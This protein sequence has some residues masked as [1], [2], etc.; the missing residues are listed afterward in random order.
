MDASRPT[1]NHR[2]A[3]I[4]IVEDDP[5]ISAVVTETL[6]DEGFRV[7][8]AT[9]HADALTALT[10]LRFGLVLTD[11]AGGSDGSGDRWPDLDRLRAAAG[12]A[13]T[14]IFSAHHPSAFDGYVERGF[15]G[16]IAKPF[17][18]DGLLTVVRGALAR[19]PVAAER[20]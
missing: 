11:T 16:F 12:D 13:P 19:Q 10:A 14:V 18:L 17:D 9:K 8:A 3:T 20:D 6:R 5:S 2:P 1:T 7:V 15:A 4:L